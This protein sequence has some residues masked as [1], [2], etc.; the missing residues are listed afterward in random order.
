ME[1]KLLQNDR[2]EIFTFIKVKFM[3]SKC[4]VDEKKAVSRARANDKMMELLPAN[5]I[6][7]SNKGHI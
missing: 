7:R 1:E 5:D 2:I 6:I 3:A 4:V